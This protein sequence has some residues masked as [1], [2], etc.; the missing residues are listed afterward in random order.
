MLPDIVASFL[1]FDTLTKISIGSAVGSL[2]LNQFVPKVGPGRA[3][4]LAVRSFF[5]S[6]PTFATMRTTDKSV[7]LSHLKVLENSR[8][9]ICKGPRGIGKTHMISDALTRTLGVVY[10]EIS[11]GTTDVDI[12]NEVHAAIANVKVGL[13]FVNSE[14]SSRRVLWWYRLL[15]RRSPIVVISALERTSAH[16]Q[17]GVPLA[18]IPGAAR[19]LAAAGFRVVVDASE[20]SISSERTRR[21]HILNV[22]PLPFEVLVSNRIFLSSFVGFISSTYNSFKG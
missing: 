8:F 4:V 1:H 14:T 11:P 7:L 22:S 17:N 5:R 10:V 12:R 6:G 21:E 2:F 9:I 16:I 3:I 20:N 19:S 15:F 18:A 13:K